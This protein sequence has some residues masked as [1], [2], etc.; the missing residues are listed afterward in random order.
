LLG[1]ILESE[2]HG[3]ATLLEAK[4]DDPDEAVMAL[5][6]AAVARSVPESRLNRSD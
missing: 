4:D 1:S 5:A 6:A 3:G 2:N